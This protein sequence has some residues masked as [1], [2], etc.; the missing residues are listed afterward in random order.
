M[1]RRKFITAAVATPV[2]VALPGETVAKDSYE[3][4][5][6]EAQWHIDQLYHEKQQELAN[7]EA[8]KELNKKFGHVA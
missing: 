4:K 8:V 5:Y 6:W 3:D 7:H 1:N 2:A